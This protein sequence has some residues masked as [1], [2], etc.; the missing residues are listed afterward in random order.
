MEPDHIA[1]VAF[2]R[3]RHAR[4]GLL[5]RWGSGGFFDDQAVGR[6]AAFRSIEGRGSEQRKRPRP[7]GPLAL[8]D[9]RE[10]AELHGAGAVNQL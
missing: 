4:G 9:R 3:K 5:G 8:A 10:L 7:S 1:A 2:T 6:V